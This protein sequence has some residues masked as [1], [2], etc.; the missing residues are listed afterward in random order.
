M[1]TQIRNCWSICKSVAVKIF[2]SI[3][4]IFMLSGL[5]HWHSVFDFVCSP[6]PQDYT[7]H[8][9]LKRIRGEQ[10]NE[11]KMMMVTFSLSLSHN[12]TVTRIHLR[13]GHSNLQVHSSLNT[14]CDKKQN[15]N[16]FSIKSITS[17][18]SHWHWHCSVCPG[19]W[20]IMLDIGV[21]WL[22][23]VDYCIYFLMIYCLRCKWYTTSTQMAIITRIID[24]RAHQIRIMLNKC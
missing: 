13:G 23:S 2:K 20:I 3:E 1:N 16:I 24:S 14:T 6:C 21:W 8:T 18:S 10:Q 12:L 22:L 19:R 7:S 15:N 17:S 5:S 9:P 11:M 4:W